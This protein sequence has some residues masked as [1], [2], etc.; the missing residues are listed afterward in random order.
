MIQGSEEWLAERAGHATASCFKEVLAKI[1]TGEAAG[2]RNYRIRLVT[3]RLTGVPVA[4][5]QNTAMQWGKDNEPAARMAYEAHTGK[6]V[7]EVGFIKHP[8]V[9]WC[10]MS[11]DGLINEDGG[12]EIK[13]PYESTIHVNTLDSGMPSEH[14]AQIQ[15]ALWVTG[16]KWWDFVSFDPRMPGKLKLY[17][18]RIERDDEYIKNLQ[19]EVIKF[20]TEVEEKY[21]AL[22]EM[23]KAA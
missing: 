9:A 16:R 11:P 10:G 17:V 3:E 12:V 4:S 23:A 5:Y 14:I 2:R 7:E 22:L 13:C 15:G 1:K 8:R 19:I 6:L 21:G 20:L 18:Q